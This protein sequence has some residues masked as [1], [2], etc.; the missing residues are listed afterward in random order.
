MQRTEKIF[1]PCKPTISRTRKSLGLADF[2]ISTVSRFPSF[3]SWFNFLVSPPA[4][5]RRFLRGGLFQVAPEL[6]ERFFGDDLE[7]QPYSTAYG[8]IWERDAESA[9]VPGGNGECV[10]EVSIRV[11]KLFEVR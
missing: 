6:R 3:R 5:A 7:L 11:R 2:T 10:N 1:V 8:K 4:Y 9:S